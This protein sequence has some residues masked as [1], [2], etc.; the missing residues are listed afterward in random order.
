[1]SQVPLCSIC[2]QNFCILAN[3]VTLPCAICGNPVLTRYICASD[4]AICGFCFTT[5]Y[6]TYLASKFNSSDISSNPI[7]TFLLLSKNYDFPIHGPEHHGLAAA[8]FLFAYHHL[9]RE[10]SQETIMNAVQQAAVLPMGSCG[11]WGACSAALGIGVAYATI[12]Q[13][14]PMKGVARGSIQKIVADII[15]RIGEY[16]APRC[17]RRETLTAL[18]VA[19]EAST[20]LLTIPIE[21]QVNCQCDQALSQVDCIRERCPFYCNEQMEPSIKV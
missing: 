10:L 17:C 5:P 20:T 14:T 2:G 9:T 13:A 6:L 8:A 15:M 11:T 7:E 4:H 21:S 12:L 16:Q 19:C 3:A 1:M 18:Q